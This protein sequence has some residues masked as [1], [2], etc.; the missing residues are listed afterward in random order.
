MTDETTK[1]D[2]KK[3]KQTTAG[4]KQ[5]PIHVIRDGGIAASIWEKTTAHGMTFLE[6]T[7]SRSWKSKNGNTGY[8][9]AYFV[10]NEAAL[11]NVVTQA[12]AYIAD[13]EQRKESE[14]LAA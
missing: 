12:A 3:K 13:A 9:Q 2:T 14:T 7:L 6:F 8:S 5:S 11:L 4:D 1:T 10:R